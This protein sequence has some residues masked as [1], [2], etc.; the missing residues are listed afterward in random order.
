MSVNHIF[1]G[2]MLN[3]YINNNILQV[4][5]VYCLKHCIMG[6]CQVQLA[7]LREVHKIIH[8]IFICYNLYGKQYHN[9]SY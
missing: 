5:W 4:H 2:E 3:S 9:Q 8:I 1:G 6:T 7:Y